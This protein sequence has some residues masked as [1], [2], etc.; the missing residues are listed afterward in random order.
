[1]HA[2]EGYGVEGSYDFVGYF[3]FA[4]GDAQTF[5]EVMAGLRDVKQNPEWK[6]VREGLE[7]WGRRVQS[8]GEML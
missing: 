7:W 4:E 8:A 6:Y 3:E 5:R 1:M 2:P